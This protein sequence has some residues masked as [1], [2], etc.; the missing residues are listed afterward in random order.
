[1]AVPFCMG[2]VIDIIYTASSQDQLIHRLNTVCAVLVGVFVVGGLA[3]FGRVYL[4]QV[5]IVCV[6]NSCIH[7]SFNWMFQHDC[8]DTYCF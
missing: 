3:N 2:K 6:M 1:M 8:L 7:V 5:M 4:M